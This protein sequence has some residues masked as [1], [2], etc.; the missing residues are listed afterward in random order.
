LL[1]GVAG[2]VLGGQL[3]WLLQRWGWAWTPAYRVAL[4]VAAL[5]ALCAAL[6]LITLRGLKEQRHV[7]QMSHE[8]RLAQR[9]LLPIGINS[10]LI[11]AGAG[12]VIPF[13]NLYFATRFGCSSAQIGWFFSVAQLTTA[14]AALLGPALAG[15]FGKLRTAV[16]SELLS[17]PFLVTLGA[18]KRLGVAVA[19][20]WA[21]ATLMQASSPLQNA[22]VMETLPPR[23]RARATSINNTVWNM[24]WA[25]S[26]SVSGLLI[27]RFGYAVPYYVTAALY[28]IAATTFYLSFRNLRESR[29]A[30]LLSEESKGRRGDSVLA[31]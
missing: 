16:A 31:E 25:V 20:F 17:L 8:E 11:G 3:P 9:H 19:S 1:A 30:P 4:I 5:A 2:N 18:E 12:L 27:E 21:R 28:G 23:L 13:F 15:R 10:L 26:A 6:P 24:G 22:F 7:E 14:A 29:A